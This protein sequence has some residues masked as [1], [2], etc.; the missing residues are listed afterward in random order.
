MGSVKESTIE[1]ILSGKHKLKAQ[2]VH[3]TFNLSHTAHRV[4]KDFTRQIGLKNAEVIKL[5]LPNYIKNRDEIQQYAVSD[6]EAS[7]RIRKTYVVEKSTLD[8]LKKIAEREQVSRDI[9]IERVALYTKQLVDLLIKRT[10]D[11][12][13]F[14]L[15]GDRES[16]D[17]SDQIGIYD[18]VEASEAKSN[19]L[20]EIIG[21]DAPVVAHLNRIANELKK[22]SE[23]IE[24]YIKTGKP[25]K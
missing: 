4:I 2:Y 3:T 16:G 5:L 23:S 24:E 7:A 13:T 12:Y 22:L 9:I 21:D 17:F 18:M 6:T 19:F 14:T 10:T 20:K 25:I 15:E 8:E 11:A 1:T